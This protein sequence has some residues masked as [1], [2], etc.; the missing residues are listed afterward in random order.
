M[1]MMA[2]QRM[3]EQVESDAKVCEGPSAPIPSLLRSR[4]WKTRVCAPSPFMWSK[5][6]I[7]S[8]RAS[9]RIAT[10]HSAHPKTARNWPV[11]IV[12]VVVDN[13]SSLPRPRDRKNTNTQHQKLALAHTHTSQFCISLIVSKKV[14]EPPH[15]S[16]VPMTGEGSSQSTGTHVLVRR[17]LSVS[18]FWTMWSAC[19]MWTREKLVWTQ[20][21]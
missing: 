17:G 4:C 14:E 10:K 8:A 20:R 16:L 11:R 21:D 3:S 13:Q 2:A 5:S 1:Q 9:W 15:P 7:L 19:T 18:D 6:R 12:W